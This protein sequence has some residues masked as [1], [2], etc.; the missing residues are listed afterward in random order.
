VTS[1][2][3]RRWL[4]LGVATALFVVVAHTFWGFVQDDAF[5]SFRYARNLVE[6]HG[7]V[8]NPG[9]R[10]EG[11]SN[12]VWTLLVA[13][14]IA[15]G[16]D[17]VR[18]SVA[19]STLSALA[20][21]LILPALAR[22]VLGPVSPTVSTLPA[23]FLAA[24]SSFALW[25]VSGMETP[26]FTLL[27]VLGSWLLLKDLGRT[28]ASAAPGAL[29]LSLAALTRPEGGLF[30]GLG[31]LAEWL[32]ARRRGTG[33]RRVVVF[34]LV[35]ASVLGPYHAW[36]L[37]YYGDLVPNTYYV[38]AAGGMY[39]V[40]L[41]LRYLR[42]LVSFNHTWLFVLLALVGVATAR[43]PVPTLYGAA[44]VLVYT[45]YM[46]KIGGDIL[47]MYRLYVPALP[48]LYVLATAGLLGLVATLDRLGGRRW[49]R[50][51]EIRWQVRGGVLT[52]LG[53]LCGVVVLL[54]VRTGL[55]HP[56]YGGVYRALQASH[57]ALARVLD[58][59]RRDG[60]VV[61]GQDMGAIPFHAARL[62]FVDVIGLTDRTVA[63][64]MYDTGYTPYLRF[65]MWGDAHARDAIVRMD[66]RIK[67]YL[68]AQDARYM[69]YNVF[70]P[71]GRPDTVLPAIERKDEA[72]F[73]PFVAE[74]T[75][76]HDLGRDPRFTGRYRL[77]GGWMYSFEYYLLLYE[78]DA[79]RPGG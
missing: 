14:P 73:A 45:L 8:F 48:F 29:V 38:K 6:G 75:F 15:L 60:D 39:A 35:A 78:R 51:P 79:T 16:A 18:F 56:E 26:L 24:S 47:P 42:D 70:V 19:L 12:F 22:A 62:R 2:K 27:V 76:Y 50:A 49:R 61:L 64:D 40:Q 20:T 23:L 66:Q 53:V 10:V 74:N 31:A 71:G 36:R 52:A 17:P 43:R 13:V 21:V 59:E 34:G 32:D 41:G 28:P 7:L 63:R 57:I 25:A 65:L 54:N 33:I 68:L 55:G 3:D 67:E 4:G 72:F 69:I 11:Y 77:R 30:V 44:A 37:V 58:A 46:V 1:P 9:E 5:I